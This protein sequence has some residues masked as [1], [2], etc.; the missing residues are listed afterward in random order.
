MVRVFLS[1][2]DDSSCWRLMPRPNYPKGV[3]KG[4]ILVL[5]FLFYLLIHSLEHFYKYE[6]SGSSLVV[7]WLRLCA[8]NAVDPSLK[9]WSGNQIPHAT[10]ESSHAA[11]KT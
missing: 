7:Q 6:F 2:C 10:S 5:S 1:F 11:T 9:T 8:P 4:D 3:A